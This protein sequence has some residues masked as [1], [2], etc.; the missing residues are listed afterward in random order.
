MANKDIEIAIVG[1]GLGGLAAAISLLQAGFDVHVYEQSRA[2][3]EVGGGELF[4]FEENREA[5]V[6]STAFRRKR[7][8]YDPS[9]ATKA[10]TRVVKPSTRAMPT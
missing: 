1:G 8:V 2:L 10:A 9:S 7:I 3:R 5:S 6:Q 4:E